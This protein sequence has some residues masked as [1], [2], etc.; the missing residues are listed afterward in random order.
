MASRELASLELTNPETGRKVSIDRTVAEQLISSPKTG[1]RGRPS[2]A[3]LIAK[4]PDEAD[5]E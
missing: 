3:Q 4:L 1:E 5:D 2:I